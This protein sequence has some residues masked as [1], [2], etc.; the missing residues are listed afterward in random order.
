MTLRI[1]IVGFGR[2]G[3]ALFRLGYNRPDIEFVAVC[4]DGDPESLVYLLNHS[5]VEGNFKTRAALDGNYITCEKQRARFLRRAEPGTIAWDCLKADVVFEC[6]GRF[7]SKEELGKHV[8]EGAGYVVASTPVTCAPVVVRG[9]NCQ[10]IPSGERVISCGS[11]SV[12]ALALALKVLEEAVGIEAASMTTIHAY[13]GDQQL[14]DAG[15]AKGRWSRSAAQNIIPNY[16]WA[17]CVV[18]EIMPSVKGKIEGIALNVPVAAGSN[19]DLTAKLKRE[20]T[21]EEVNRYFMRAAEGD[22]NGL[23][24]Y[25]DEKIVSSDII[26]DTRTAVLDSAAT[27]ALA[28]GMVKTLLWFDNGWSIAQRMLETAELL[29]NKGG[30]S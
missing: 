7:G 2:V 11:S 16:T 3:R 5:T 22:L 26:G 1:G 28:G 6:T 21:A 8:S 20:L 17:P 27:I 4:D 24:G 15:K 14:S 23:L 30:K 18:E 13:T 19:I 12:Q 25:T 9:I 29:C 10:N